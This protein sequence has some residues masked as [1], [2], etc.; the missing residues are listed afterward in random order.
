MEDNFCKLA[1]GVSPAR[2]IKDVDL[3]AGFVEAHQKFVA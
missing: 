3:V 1:G 2:E